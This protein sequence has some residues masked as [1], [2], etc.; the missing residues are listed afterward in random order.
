MINK[1]KA[2]ISGITPFVCIIVFLLLGFYKGMWHPGWLVFLLIP[3]VSSLLYTKTLN[4]VFSI[5]ILVTYLSIGFTSQVWHPTW[6]MFLLIPI[7]N[8]IFP[9]RKK[10]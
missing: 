4:I 8:I 7:F 1:T 10:I 6:I 9:K 2:K 3:I 5:A